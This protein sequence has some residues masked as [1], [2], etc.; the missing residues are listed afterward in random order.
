MRIALLSDID[1]NAI[2]LDAVLADIAAL[3]GADEYGGLGDLMA[4]GPQP[5]T[6]LERLP[7]R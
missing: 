1:G 7:A 2:A 5:V 6:V 3:G 4:L